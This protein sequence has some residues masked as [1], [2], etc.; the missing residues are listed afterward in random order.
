MPLHGCNDGTHSVRLMADINR[1]LGFT[2]LVNLPH[3]SKLLQGPG[4]V[5]AL[6]SQCK[7]SLHLLMSRGD[8][9]AFSCVTLLVVAYVQQLCCCVAGKVFIQCQT[10]LSASIHES[11]ECICL[12]LCL[13]S[14]CCMYSAA[15]LLFCCDDFHSVQSGSVCVC[16]PTA[17]DMILALSAGS[18]CL[19]PYL[20]AHHC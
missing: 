19:M 12:S 9:T 5:D 18:L 6:S 1:A 20:M 2:A 13:C 10:G 4:P 3:S 14:R 17:T 8:V 11:W 7:K 15:L 16:T